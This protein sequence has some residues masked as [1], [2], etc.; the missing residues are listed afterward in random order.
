MEQG[1]YSIDGDNVFATITEDRTMDFDKTNW[2]SH[3][4]YIDLQYVIA[5]EEKIG[6]WPVSKA[7]VTKKY[8]QKKMRQIT[9]QKVR[10]MTLSWEHFSFSFL[11]MRIVRAIYLQAILF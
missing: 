7:T 8:N 5:G 1:K 9:V 10:Y 6:V 3:G 4:N 2:E 11:Q